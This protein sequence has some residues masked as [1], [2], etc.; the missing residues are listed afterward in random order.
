MGF[1][2]NRGTSASPNWTKATKLFV[3]KGTASASNWVSVKKAFINKGS[4]NWV[5]FWPK[6][7]PYADTLPTILDSSNSDITSLSVYRLGTTVQIKGTSG[8]WQPNGYTIN[9]FTVNLLGWSALTGGTLTVLSGPTTIT[10][11]LASGTYTGPTQTFTLTP[12]STYDKKYLDF[13]V[14]ANTTT[15]GITGEDFSGE[16]NRLYIV[17]NQ[18]SLTSSSLFTDPHGVGATFYYE[19]VWNGTDGYLP[20]SAR[21]SVVWYTNTTKSTTGGTLA[22]GTV[23][24]TTS[25]VSNVYK[26][27]SSYTPVVADVGKYLYAVNTEYNSGTDYD[28]GSTTIGVVN[29]IVSTSTVV[30]APTQITAPSLTIKDNA[31]ASASTAYT[32]YTMSFAGGTYND[33][34]TVRTYLLGKTSSANQ[35]NGL[36]VAVSTTTSPRTVQGS[37]ATNGYYFVVQDVVTGTNGKVYY[38]YST[39]N[40]Q[41]T[42]RT[43]ISFNYG[44]SLSNTTGWDAYVNAYETGATYSIVSTSAG[45]SV[46]DGAGTKIGRAHV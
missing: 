15:S 23:V 32:G 19:G 10:A 35:D 34:S 2:V 41:A 42:I 25:L 24:N 26:A 45:S 36:N 43:G 5:Q 20:E 16:T 38:F 46:V 11:T 33:S 3:N 12:G 29:K 44:T 9:G 27:T 28:N 14:I 22:T 37:D 8:T 18:P 4:N 13:D 7:G 17:R 40:Y 6:N 30:N 1:F 39:P 31:G 21:S